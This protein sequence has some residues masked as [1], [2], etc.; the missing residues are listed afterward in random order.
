MYNAVQLVLNQGLKQRLNT[1]LIV[2]YKTGETLAEVKVKK[3]NFSRGI[4]QRYNVGYA[5]T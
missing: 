2:I 1:P 4:N 5:M 3:K